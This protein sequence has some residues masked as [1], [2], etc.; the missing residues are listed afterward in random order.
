V[1][2]AV[3]STDGLRSVALSVG[4]VLLAASAVG[5]VA[6]PI[7]LLLNLSDL[8]TRSGRHAFAGA[9]GLTALAVLEFALAVIPIRRGETWALIAAGVPFV[10]VGVPVLIVDATHVAPERL[11]QT[12]APQVAGLFVGVTGWFLCAVGIPR[13][14]T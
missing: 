13:R 6:A 12:L 1:S 7:T 5:L 11:W 9:S 8:S 4:W 10:V 2:D 3:R 14:A